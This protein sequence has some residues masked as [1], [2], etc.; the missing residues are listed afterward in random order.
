MRE[1]M[2][3][4][5]FGSSRWVSEFELSVRDIKLKSTF[6]TNIFVSQEPVDATPKSAPHHKLIARIENAH[7][8][9]DVNTVV[10]CPRKGYESLL[11]TAGDDGVAKVWK[12]QGS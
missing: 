4:S 2:G 10:W 3:G 8:V 9:D 12:I 5:I 6:L 1:G 7:G 11:A